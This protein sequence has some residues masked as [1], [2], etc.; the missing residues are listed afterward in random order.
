MLSD[1]YSKQILSSDLINMKL[2]DTEIAS[3]SDEKKHWHVT[4][5]LIYADGREEVREYF[6]TVVDDCS[7]LIACLMKA[8][9][10]YSGVTY[11]A[12]G[13][14]LG[15]WDNAN[16]PAP[17]TTDVKLTT[18]TFRKAIVPSTDIKFLDASNVETAS[19][20]NKIQIKVTF[21]ETEANGEL[22]E[23]ALFGGNASATANS[24]LMINRK[25]H[26][27]IYK[28]SGMKLERTIRLV[29]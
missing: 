24:G 16:P 20:T 13:S 3:A 25:T 15:T 11:W 10:G 4:D 18:E 29:F 2:V 22:R 14:G 5:R 23:F 27:L 21:S 28:T 19:I 8:Q 26:G 7:K 6:N 17:A 9:A 12:V 1:T